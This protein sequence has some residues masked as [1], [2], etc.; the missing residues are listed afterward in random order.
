MGAFIGFDGD[1]SSVCSEPRGCV[2][3]QKRGAPNVTGKEENYALA[4]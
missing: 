4:A 3:R 1:R 2:L